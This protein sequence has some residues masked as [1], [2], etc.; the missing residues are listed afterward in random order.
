MPLDTASLQNQIKMA[1]KKAKDTPAPSDPK[2]ADQAQEQ[3]LTQLSQDLAAAVS[4]FVR[5][6]DVLNVTVQVKDNAS[7]IIG[8]GTQTT[9]VQLQ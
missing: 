8:I 9:P 7:A 6:G 3:I 2:D 5:G 1:F 4:A